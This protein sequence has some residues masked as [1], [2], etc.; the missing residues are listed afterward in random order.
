MTSRR[1]RL[2]ARFAAP[3]AFLLAATVAVLLVRS[4]L[5]AGSAGESRRERPPAAQQRTQAQPQ[6]QTRPQRRRPRRQQPQAVYY[7]VQPNDT[8]ETIA[9]EHGTSVERLLELNAGI[10]PRQLRVNQRIRV[11]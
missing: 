11:R 6:P 5:D 9:S 2:F 8:L 4:A 1:N 10:D 7:T 3:A